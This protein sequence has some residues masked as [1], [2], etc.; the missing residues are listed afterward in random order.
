MHELSNIRFILGM[1]RMVILI[2][3]IMS[4]VLVNLALIFVAIGFTL[5]YLSVEDLVD[6]E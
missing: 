3:V 4:F 6:D 1:M 2:T 5:V